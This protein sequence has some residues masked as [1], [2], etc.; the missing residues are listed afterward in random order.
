MLDQKYKQTF[1]EERMPFEV[2]VPKDPPHT[3]PGGSVPVGAERSKLPGTEHDPWASS[4]GQG[5]A[6]SAPFS[7]MPFDTSVGSGFPSSNFSSGATGFNSSYNMNDG[8]MMHTLT[9][10]IAQFTAL[11]SFAAS[12][13]Y[14][15]VFSAAP[16]N[17]DGWG[18]AGTASAQPSSHFS[19]QPLGP[20]DVGAV[21]AADWSCQNPVGSS[22]NE[23]PQGNG[24]PSSGKGALSD[25]QSRKSRGGKGRSGKDSNAAAKSDQ[26]QQTS[27][28]KGNRGGRQNRRS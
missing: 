12:N 7:T 15:V 1:P 9:P 11:P 23:G 21:G 16:A 28:Q 24:L 13:R 22:Q 26:N 6:S 27:N 4:A 17:L 20:T 18:S 14:N 25:K 5:P 8:L 19:Q 3:T 10:Q 2:P